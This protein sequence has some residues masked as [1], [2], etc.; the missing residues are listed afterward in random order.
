MALPHIWQLGCWFGSQCR[1]FGVTNGWAT[2][3]DRLCLKNFTF[4]Y[5]K[6]LKNVLH[7][8]SLMLLTTK[9][10]TI[11]S[12]KIKENI[13]IKIYIVSISLILCMKNNNLFFLL[14]GDN[15]FKKKL[16]YNIALSL[17]C[18]SCYFLYFT[19]IFPFHF[20]FL[21][22][23]TN[24]KLEYRNFIFL[25]TNFNKSEVFRTRGKNKYL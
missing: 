16:I 23:I 25:R 24:L 3:F 6:L 22:Q 8:I 14:G 2:G 21:C 11:F 9:F 1:Q 5:T 10:A 18:Y 12:P 20:F 7:V 15:H 19:I 17:F 4:Y 13:K